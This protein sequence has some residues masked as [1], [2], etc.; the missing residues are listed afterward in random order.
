VLS[1]WCLCYG[2]SPS[3]LDRIMYNQSIAGDTDYNIKFV[4]MHAMK[5]YGGVNVCFHSCLT[6]T[7]DEVE[8][9]ASRSEKRTPGTN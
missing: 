3:K 9:E 7:L 4:Y 8:W 1:G 2:G 6:S 5:T